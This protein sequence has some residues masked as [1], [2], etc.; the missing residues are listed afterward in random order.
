[1]KAAIFH[2]AGKPHTFEDVEIDAPKGHEVLVRTVAC[3]VCHSDASVAE[4][5]VAVP[6]PMILGH[7]P[8]GIVEATGS[9]VTGLKPG[10]HVIARLGLYCGRCKHCLSGHPN[11]CNN[12]ASM[13]RRTG[14]HPRMMYRGK[15]IAGVTGDGAGF[16]EKMLTHEHGFVKIP[17]SV[18]LEAAALVGCAVVTGMGAVLNTAKVEAGSTVAVFG[19]GGIG[20]SAI[21]G[22][23]IA[24]ARRIIAVD[25]N[26]SKLAAARH[27]GATDTVDASSADPVAAI[28]KLTGDGVDYAFEA[29]GLKQTAEQCIQSLTVGGTATIIGILGTGQKVEIDPMSLMAEKRVQGCLMG[30]VRF[31]IDAPRYIDFYQQGRLLLD[32][33]VTRRIRLEELDEAFAAI[34]RGEVLR[35]V[36]MFE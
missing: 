32:E 33:M 17:E 11:R 8:A 30:S 24:G 12:R 10:D 1:M 5:K 22:A 3:G 27:F 36:I 20:L 18:P 14:E 19:A 34:N 26:E 16:A 23:R 9:D 28:M 2:E 29:I 6:T 31:P 21:Q 7:E 35:S 4:G 15:P 13:Q 25:V